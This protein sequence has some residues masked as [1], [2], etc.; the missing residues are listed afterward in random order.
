[1]ALP[2]RGLIVCEPLARFG[3]LLVVSW[4]VMTFTHE[5]VTVR[6]GW[7]SAGR[8]GGAPPAVG[9][10]VQHLRSGPPAARHA[11]ER[12]GPRVL[13]RSR[14]PPPSAGMGVGH[15]SLLPAGQRSYLAIAWAKGRQPVGH[16]Q[17]LA[18]GAYPANH[19]AYACSP[20]ASGTRVS[21]ATALGV[22]AARRWIPWADRSHQRLTVLSGQSAVGGL[23]AADDGAGDRG[24][25][26]GVRGV[27]AAVPRQLWPGT[28]G[29]HIRHLLP[30][31]AVGPAPQ[32]VSSQSPSKPAPRC[33]S[34]GVPGHRRWDTTTPA[35][36][37]RRTWGP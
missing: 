31:V 37:S 32:R 28:D 33:D 22:V 13:V 35:P 18:R 2:L 19:R 4:C 8:S 7:A 16:A 10:A 21:A 25:R 17:L 1:V 11:V 14:W 27:P 29:G 34:P 23:G 15:L 3:L 24:P 5:A 9:A 26:P 20:S 36:T 30:G 12:P 6:G